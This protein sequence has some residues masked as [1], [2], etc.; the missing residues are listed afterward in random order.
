MDFLLGNNIMKFNK[1]ILS[2]LALGYASSL[3]LTG[4]RD[5]DI[6]SLGHGDGE[7]NILS[8]KS[9]L[10]LNLNI[11]SLG[12]DEG[13]PYHPESKHGEGFENYV[14]AEGIRVFFC[15]LEGNFLFE[16]NKQNIFLIEKSDNWVGKNEHSDSYRLIIPRDE[17]RQDDC[18]DEEKEKRHNEAIRKA[19]YEDGFKVAVLA[20]W[21]NLIEGERLKD[22]ETGDEFLGSGNPVEQHLGFKWFD[23]KGGEVREEDRPRESKIGYLSQC[24]YDNVY[25]EPIEYGSGIYS[26]SY[27]HLVYKHDVGAGKG[28][29]GMFTS[30]VSY[31]YKNHN[32]AAEFIRKGEDDYSSYNENTVGTVKYTYSTGYKKGH[33]GDPDYFTYTPYSYTRTIDSENKYDMENIMRLWNF[34]GFY[35]NI[36]PFH[37]GMGERAKT[38]WK[39]RNDNTLIYK[40]NKLYSDGQEKAFGTITDNK[41]ELVLQGNNI[42]TTYIPVSGSSGGYLKMKGGVKTADVKKLQPEINS[43]NKQES[44][45]FQNGSIM[46]RAYGEGILRMRVKAAGKGQVAVMTRVPETGKMEIINIWD[47]SPMG[48]RYSQ[49]YIFEPGKA[50]NKRAGIPE[51]EYMINPDSREYLEVYIAAVEGTVDFYEM[52]YIR[53]RHVYDSARNAVMPSE[54]NPIPMYGIQNFDPI[55]AYIDV[56][57]ENECFNLSDKDYNWYLKNH[58][59]LKSYNFKNIYLLRSVAK[60]ELR[61]KKSIFRNNLPQH[62]FMRVMN[63]T[64]RCEP[65]DVVNPTNWIWYGEIGNIDGSHAQYEGEGKIDNW[66]SEKKFPGANNEFK[67][68][69]EYYREYPLYDI[70]KKGDIEE[71]RKRTAWF[72]GFWGDNDET[73][74]AELQNRYYWQQ[75]WDWNKI[76][77]QTDIPDFSKPFPRI[78]N[79]RIDRS[80]YCRFHKLPDDGTEYIRYV[81][82]VPEKNISDTD[83]K[84]DLGATPKIQH[85]EL[86]FTNMNGVMNFDDNLCYRIYFTDYTDANGYAD[87]GNNIN[88]KYDRDGA[89]ETGTYAE[90]EKNKDWLNRLQPVMRNCHYIFTIESVND[91]QLGVKMSVCGAASRSSRNFII[92]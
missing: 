59:E 15:D 65:K 88:D 58:P 8:P 52:E 55:G 82:Y 16:A 86:R 7:G 76:M 50:E 57:P 66:A 43:S 4:C 5:D 77:Y 51:V 22:P 71:Y 20:N 79:T 46:F 2:A 23:S 1:Y 36:C 74:S 40:L 27:E 85:I 38:Y 45:K 39:E 28:Q 35:S 90:F 70:N 17:L 30:W 63:R 53:S 3:L 89:T 26:P 9:S 91:K 78:F 13:S 42:G 72:Y 19:I 12:N 41:G 56:I 11:P 80:D 6:Y 92:N 25:G 31:I 75:P 33:E 24:V 37:E 84:G 44:D 21:P 49:D 81:M 29:M 54:E 64:A 34:S 14:S 83:S 61:F 67:N 73:L 18:G 10:I 62:L 68:I 69:M 87:N 48:G 47:P 32:A 60:V